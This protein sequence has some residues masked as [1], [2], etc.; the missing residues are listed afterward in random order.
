MLF[1]FVAA[2]MPR[3]L[4]GQ[5]FPLV[6]FERNQK[7]SVYSWRIRLPKEVPGMAQQ[8]AGPNTCAK[9]SSSATVP[10]KSATEGHTR[11]SHRLCCEASSS[12]CQQSQEER[13]P[14]RQDPNAKVP[15]CV[16]SSPG[17]DYR[18]NSCRDASINPRAGPSTGLAFTSKR[19]T[20]AS[21]RTLGLTRAHMVT[22]S[23]QDTRST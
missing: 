10:R 7:S 2:A 18:P 5:F 1:P 19:A 20:A 22:R 9:S 16:V 17:N 15:S 21:S 3:G 6:D 11:K 8:S 13:V 23:I 14:F 12:E 4:S